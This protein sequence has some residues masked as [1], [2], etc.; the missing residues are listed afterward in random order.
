LSEKQSDFLCKVSEGHSG[1]AEIPEFKVWSSY[2][3]NL[4]PQSHFLGNQLTYLVFSGGA[5]L[6]NSDSV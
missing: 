1:E 3:P 4:P 6:S 5:F 2:I